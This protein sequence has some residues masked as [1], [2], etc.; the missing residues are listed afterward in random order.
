MNHPSTHSPI[1]PRIIDL[2]GTFRYWYQYAGQYRDGKY[3]PNGT[4]APVVPLGY[5]FALRS[6][7]GGATL[8]PDMINLD[9]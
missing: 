3:V 4:A 2:R 5:A 8:Q 7:D 6:V 1:T 9:G